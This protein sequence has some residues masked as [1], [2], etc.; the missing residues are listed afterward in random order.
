MTRTRPSISRVRP[1]IISPGWER[2]RGRLTRQFAETAA[3]LSTQSP[4]QSAAREV[5]PAMETL[6]GLN[7]RPLGPDPEEVLTG[8]YH[9]E[10]PRTTTQIHGENCATGAGHGITIRH[11]LIPASAFHRRAADMLFGN[12][13]E[14]STQTTL[15]FK[16]TLSSTNRQGSQPYPSG[17]QE[18]ISSIREALETKLAII[19]ESGTLHTWMAHGSGECGNLWDRAGVVILNVLPSSYA[20]T[21]QQESAP[22]PESTPQRLSGIREDSENSQPNWIP[23]TPSS[24]YPDDGN[25]KS[26]TYSPET[27]T[28]DTSTGLSIEEEAAAN[29]LSQ[30]FWRDPSQDF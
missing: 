9:M 26:W 20:T 1:G 2:I 10:L 17:Y 11:S 30:D 25:L 18:L 12:S 27:P 4:T 14:E 15:I 6:P 23:E 22:S 7:E 19:A 29:L 28:T 3:R 16:V 21:Q 13:N 5:L 8:L 24:S